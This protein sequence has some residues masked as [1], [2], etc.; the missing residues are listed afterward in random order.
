MDHHDL[1]DGVPPRGAVLPKAAT[2]AGRTNVGVACRGSRD[3][4]GDRA[5]ARSQSAAGPLRR[6]TPMPPRPGGVAIA[7][8]VSSVEN[9]SSQLTVISSQLTGELLTDCQL[10]TGAINWGVT[11]VHEMWTVFEN[12]S[13]TLS[14]VTPG[15]SATA[16]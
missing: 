3:P 11:S 4:R 14:V 8:M 16:M 15:T 2:V 10:S 1:V 12:A 5:A 6:T 13:P 9:T 7:T